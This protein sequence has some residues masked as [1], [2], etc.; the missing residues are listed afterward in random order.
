MTDVLIAFYS[1]RG[2]NLVGGAVREL[3]V[4]NT[5]LAAK[6]IQRLTGGDLFQIEPVTAYPADYYRCIDL[7]R[8]DLRKG[9]R[10]ALARWP[11]EPSRY[12][13]LYLGYPN[14]WG[15][16]PVAVFSFVGGLALDGVT[17]KPFCTYEESGMG[18]SEQDLRR[19]CPTARVAPGFPI[20]GGEAEYEL[21]ALKDWIRES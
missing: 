17:I 19:L 16:M 11:K 3:A 8:R 10:P 13:T 9:A 18:R 7:A 12:K 21:S 15:T 14:Y 20:H 2:G 6:V 1:R 4:G 5:E